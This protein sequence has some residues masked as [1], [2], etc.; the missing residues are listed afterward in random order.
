M[1]LFFSTYIHRW[2][3]YHHTQNIQ[4]PSKP[5]AMKWIRL[6]M[7]RTPIMK[8][9]SEPLTLTSSK[10]IFNH[11]CKHKFQLIIVELHVASALDLGYWLK[12]LLVCLIFK[13]NYLSQQWKRAEI[14]IILTIR[15]ELLLHLK[16]PLANQCKGNRTVYLLVCLRWK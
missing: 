16:Q 6:N 1:R 2:H 9:T 13:I 15:I 5:T 12:L 7:E 3:H 14:S 10:N 8:I 4:W 11:V